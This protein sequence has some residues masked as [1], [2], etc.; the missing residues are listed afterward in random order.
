MKA[1]IDQIRQTVSIHRAKLIELDE[2]VFSTRPEPSRWSPKEIVGHLVD[3]AQNN[4]QRFVRA[5]YE[6]MPRIVY[7]QDQWVRLSGYQQYTR[8]EIVDLWTTINKHLLHVLS[9]LDRGATEKVVDTGKTSQQLRTLQFLAEDY[10]S[11]MIHHLDQLNDR[12]NL[13]KKA[14]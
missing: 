3:S 5:Q 12:V 2:V 11:H 13:I 6:A 7:D 14:L 1:L 8:Q 9:N 4:I 10:H